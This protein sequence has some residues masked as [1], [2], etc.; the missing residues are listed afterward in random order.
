MSRIELDSA[1][2]A[3]FERLRGLAANWNG[4]GAPAIDGAL[5]DAARAFVAALPADL[6]FHPV[7]V[8]M[9]AGNLQFEWHEGQRSL[10]LEVEDP[11]TIHFLK[12]DPFKQV[13][14]EGTFSIRDVERAT[15]LIRWIGEGGANA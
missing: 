2:D 3:E 7:V 11:R 12:W 15:G 4:Y 8:P 14:D 6:A 1:I 5:I 10:E 13:E 9:S